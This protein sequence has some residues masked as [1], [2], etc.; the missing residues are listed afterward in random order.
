[1]GKQ[2]RGLA[3]ELSWTAL[4]MAFSLFLK[5]RGCFA[6]VEDALNKSVVSVASQVPIPSSLLHLFHQDTLWIKEDSQWEGLVGRSPRVI[7]ENSYQL[8]ANSR[9]ILSFLPKF[10]EKLWEYQAYWWGGGNSNSST[11]QPKVLHNRIPFKVNILF[12]KK[13]CLAYRQFTL[14]H[15]WR[16]CAAVLPKH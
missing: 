12:I 1:M 2:H 11:F 5:S 7:K 3:V 15:K 9:K 13:Y 16:S 10:S 6:G 14:S 4:G 8:E